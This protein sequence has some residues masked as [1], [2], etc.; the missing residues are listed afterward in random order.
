MVYRKSNLKTLIFFMSMA[1]SFHTSDEDQ[2]KIAE[3]IYSK[4]RIHRFRRKYKVEAD[5]ETI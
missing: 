4:N 3:E 5:M 2:R 1:Q